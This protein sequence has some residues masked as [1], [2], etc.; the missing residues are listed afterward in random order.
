VGHSQL[1]YVVK[2]KISHPKRG[3]QKNPQITHGFPDDCPPPLCMPALFLFDHLILKAN[4]LTGYYK[5]QQQQP[6]TT[7]TANNNNHTT[8]KPQPYYKDK[9]T[10][11]QNNTTRIR[12]PTCPKANK[13]PQPQPLK[14]FPRCATSSRR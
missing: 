14:S 11:I 7:T 10:T 8:T 5:R 2:A 13:D 6:P 12:Q 4:V 3:S 9:G 1:L